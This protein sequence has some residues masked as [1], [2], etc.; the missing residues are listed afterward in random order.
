L[1]TRKR[2]L[3]R[4]GGQIL[5]MFTL[6]LIPMFGLIGLVTDLGY[7]HFIKMSA[8]TAA[9]AAAS[10]AVIDMRVHG[11]AGI[12]FST[13]PT[14]CAPN[15]TSPANALEHGCMYAQQHGFNSANQVTYQS[16]TG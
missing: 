14:T 15:I 6:A 2:R 11:T 5:L 7:M 9:Q 10:A 8:Q 13:T 4:R 3:D 1:D 16:G 12:T